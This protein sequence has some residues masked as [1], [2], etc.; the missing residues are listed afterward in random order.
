MKV[1]I[2]CILKNNKEKNGVVSF[3]SPVL[4]LFTENDINQDAENNERKKSIFEKE[5]NGFV[6]KL[7]KSCLRIFLIVC[8]NF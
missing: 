3:I 6:L 4:I 2:N 8:V 1:E 5:L 7:N